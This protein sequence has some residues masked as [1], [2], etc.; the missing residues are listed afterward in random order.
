MARSCPVCPSQVLNPVPTSG[1]DIDV[2]P[3][4]NGMWF[5]R[6]QLERF[7]ERPSV[8]AFLPSARQAPSRC[9]KQGH[10][11]PR[12]LA[13]CDTCR[14]APVGCPN[15]GSR[16]S[17]VKTSACAIDICV[18]CEGVWLDAG[19]FELLRGVNGPKPAPAPVL[20]T[21]PSPASSDWE[22][23]VATDKGPDPWLAPG[24]K[25]AL[26]PSGDVPKLNTRGPL[27]CRHCGK[28][29][30]VGRA[31]ARDGDLY[32]ETCRP[33]GAVSGASLP[34]DDAPKTLR[35]SGDDAVGLL[36]IVGFIIDILT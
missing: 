21:K 6:G 13:A 3:R 20:R 18:H 10:L 15:C 7:P 32:C 33:P 9:R 25:Q 35:M 8:R 14:G 30:V 34:A 29:V 24:S 26:E 27:D 31:W 19:E 1:V 28:Q 23:P 2:C 22:I 12:A 17:L 11:V 36:Q 4:C 5:D 16:L